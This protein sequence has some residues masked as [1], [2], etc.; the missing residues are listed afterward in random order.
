[1]LGEEI[2]ELYLSLGDIKGMYRDG[3]EIDI[4]I[5][6][7]GLPRNQ[8]N[9][10]IFNKIVENVKRAKPLESTKYCPSE[11]ILTP[12]LGGGS[13]KKPSGGRVWTAEKTEEMYQRFQILYDQG[14]NDKDIGIACGCTDSRV[15]QW[16]K[17]RNLPLN[18]KKYKNGISHVCRTFEEMEELRRQMGILYNKYP[19]MND[20]GMSEV[21]KCNEST[22]QHWRVVNGLPSHRDRRKEKKEVS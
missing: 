22:I 20:K 1:M 14:E 3:T 19:N 21:L 2:P 4:L 16:R 7:N 10:K 12:V 18:P 11:R 6:L 15:R 5:D 9:R 17:R 13:R 8:E